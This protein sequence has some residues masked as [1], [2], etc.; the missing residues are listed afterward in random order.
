MEQR[1]LNRATPNVEAVRA[2]D[3]KIFAM[4]TLEEEEMLNFFRDQ[5][6]R[7]GVSVSIISESDT[8]DLAAAK[9]RQE[10][11]AILKRSN[12]RISVTIKGG[13]RDV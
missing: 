8:R 13:S 2:L 9:S 6:R 12:S 4:L 10:A 11:D 1:R 7:Y 3:G 5:G